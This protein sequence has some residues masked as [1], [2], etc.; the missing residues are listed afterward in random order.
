MIPNASMTNESWW[1][2]RNVLAHGNLMAN[3]CKAA[4]MLADMD[5]EV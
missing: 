1:L 5:E 4:M 3:G 2:R